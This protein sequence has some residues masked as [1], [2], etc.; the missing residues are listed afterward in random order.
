[1]QSKSNKRRKKNPK[2]R[3]VEFFNLP[4]DHDEMESSPPSNE[5]QQGDEWDRSEIVEVKKN[6][7]P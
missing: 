7:V 2:K 3:A 4:S 6:L 5:E 1:M